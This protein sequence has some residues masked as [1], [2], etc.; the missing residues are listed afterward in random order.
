MA[1]NLSQPFEKSAMTQQEKRQASK[2]IRRQFIVFA[3]MI[4]LTIIAFLTVAADVVPRT[5]AIPFVLLL[6]LIQFTLQLLFF[7]HM[8]DKDHGWANVFMITGI[9]VTV[10]TI[11]AL[12]LLLGVTKW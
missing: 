11:A 4:F 9:F 10:P 1:D 7:M 8:K 6:A 12:M 2:E 3:L 5:F